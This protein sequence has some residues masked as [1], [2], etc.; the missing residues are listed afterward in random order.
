[1]IIGSFSALPAITSLVSPQANYRPQRDQPCWETTKNHKQTKHG[2]LP[3]KP[4]VFLRPPHSSSSPLCGFVAAFGRPSFLFLHLL[5]QRGGLRTLCT[6]CSSR[7][8][9]NKSQLTAN[10]CWRCL[11]IRR[12]LTT[13]ITQKATAVRASN[14]PEW[15]I[16]KGL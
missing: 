2:K 4:S 11:Q 1:M 9:T 3:I 16:G 6:R 15:T 8:L 12:I 10:C 14:P 5:L 7:P 13:A